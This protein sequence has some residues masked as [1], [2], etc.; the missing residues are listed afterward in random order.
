MRNRWGK[1]QCR[2]NLLFM[3]Q[4]RIIDVSL[5]CGLWLPSPPCALYHNIIIIIAVTNKDWGVTMRKW[6]PRWTLQCWSIALCRHWKNTALYRYSSVSLFKVWLFF[7]KCNTSAVMSFKVTFKGWFC[8]YKV[9]IW[10]VVIHNEVFKALGLRRYFFQNKCLQRMKVRLEKKHKKTHL[11]S[12]P[13]SDFFLGLA[14]GVFTC[15]RTSICKRGIYQKNQ[16][17]LVKMFP[18][19]WSTWC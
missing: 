5:G 12:L 8:L 10:W 16:N 15:F 9:I 14:L 4:Q 7:W 6:S 19:S 13:L 1:R 2:G 17:R 11:S 18:S 3:R